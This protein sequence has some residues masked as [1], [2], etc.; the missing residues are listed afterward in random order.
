MKRNALLL[1]IVLCLAGLIGGVYC[2]QRSQAKPAAPETLGK[3]APEQTPPQE[4]PATKPPK[5]EPEHKPELEEGSYLDEESGIVYQPVELAHY[6]IR[7]DLPAGWEMDAANPDCLLLRTSEAVFSPVQLMVAF[8]PLASQNPEKLPQ[9]AADFMSRNFIYKKNGAAYDGGFDY[10]PGRNVEVVRDYSSSRRIWFNQ[11][12]QD[13]YQEF[14]E[15]PPGSGEGWVQAAPFV[16]TVQT[17]K[18]RFVYKMGE[19]LWVNYENQYVFVGDMGVVVGFMTTDNYTQAAQRMIGTIRQ[20]IQPL[21]KAPS[22]LPVL[23]QKAQLGGL[24]FSVSSDFE[25]A[26]QGR[27][28][29]TLR[30]RKVGSPF[31]G[32]DIV[33]VSFKK[34]SLAG[35][36]GNEGDFKS[37]VLRRISAGDIAQE[38][39]A[40]PEM[41]KGS[42]AGS[43]AANE[44]ISGQIGFSQAASSDLV[45]RFGRRYPVRYYAYGFQQGD[46]LFMVIVPYAENTKGLACKLLGR[47]RDDI[48]AQRKQQQ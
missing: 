40:H 38:V 12:S 22:A 5:Q 48:E 45:G 20:S 16:C 24:K 30:C 15:I 31:Y 46:D 28:A 29:M 35:F 44:I 34:A 26:G 7:L 1:A 10:S 36:T 2:W 39:A 27:W 8:Y 21:K 33:G 13:L 9:A 19:E 17:G 3:I 42:I 11:S 32:M 47:I 14:D 43:P 25:G 6:G 23:D 41:L 37:D 4:R 18:G